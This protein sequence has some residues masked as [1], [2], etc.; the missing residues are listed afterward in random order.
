MQWVQNNGGLALEQDYSYKMAD[1][2]CMANIKNSGVVVRGYVNVTGEANLQD[3]VANHGPVAVA[4]NAAMKDFYYLQGNGVY[5]NPNCDPNDRDHEVL[6]VGYG[7]QNGQDYWLVKN[8]WG[9]IWGDKGFFK[10]A[11]NAGNMC[12]IASEARYALL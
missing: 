7:T 2:Y 4:I 10:M 6:V 9:V 12:G 8:S 3:A 1:A 11:R 5:S